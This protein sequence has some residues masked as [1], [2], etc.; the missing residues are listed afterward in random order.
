VK[1]AKSKVTMVGQA[2][3][4]EDVVMVSPVK[5][6][7]KRTKPVKIMQ[8]VA[9]T[10]KKPAPLKDSAASEKDREWNRMLEQRQEELK[11]KHQRLDEERAKLA[12]QEKELEMEQVQLKLK[13]LQ[14]NMDTLPLWHQKELEKLRLAEVQARVDMLN[15]KDVELLARNQRM[16]RENE[17]RMEGVARLQSQR[18]LD[19]Q[20]RLFENKQRKLFESNQRQLLSAEMTRRSVESRDRIIKPIIEM[21]RDK[22][23]VTESDDI[24]FS[25]DDKELIVNGKKQPEEIFESFKH[26]FLYNSDDYIKYSKHGGTE[27]TSINR[28]KD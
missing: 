28:H 17:L 2:P 24:S 18:L 9:D 23:L 13:Y 21:L 27:S 26:E 20:Q 10:S 22:G 3:P 8:A 7:M 4:V 25:L 15:H 12:E 16:L 11:V 1:T 19:T 5:E 14:A 6:G